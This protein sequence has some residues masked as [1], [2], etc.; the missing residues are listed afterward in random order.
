MCRVAPSVCKALSRSVA[1]V[2]ILH[3]ILFEFFIKILVCITRALLCPC[4]LYILCT[5]V[6]SSSFVCLSMCLILHSQSIFYR[7]LLGPGGVCGVTSSG[8]PR[9]PTRPASHLTGTFCAGDPDMAVNAGH[10]RLLTKAC[11][12]VFCAGL[13]GPM[14]TVKYGLP[15]VNVAAIK[16]S[17]ARYPLLFMHVKVSF[18][19]VSP[20]VSGRSVS[21]SYCQC[22]SSKMSS[23]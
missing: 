23:F 22:R 14:C 6:P 16:K 3:I 15:P 4:Y 8:Q 21:L 5:C 20:V 19:F 1:A 17:L 12:R 18:L 9:T 2:D 7:P 11:E 13:N 10:H